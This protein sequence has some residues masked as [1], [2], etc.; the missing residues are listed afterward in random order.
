M[1]KYSLAVLLL[2]S[3]LAFA[4]GMAFADDAPFPVYQTPL[5]TLNGSDAVKAVFGWDEKP[6]TFFWFDASQG[7]DAINPALTLQ[8]TN[9]WKH[10]GTI[11][12]TQTDNFAGTPGVT[13]L[14]DWIGLDTWSGVRQ[15]GNWTVDSTWGYVNGT[16]PMC[17]TSS[18][19]VTPEPFSAALFLIGGLAIASRKFF[20]KK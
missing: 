4:S 1:K 12:G 7:G 20:T 5:T 16:N 10:E 9:V 2:M 19:T 17:A 13:T 15:T 11:I 6:F 14:K 3:S 8:V 18:F